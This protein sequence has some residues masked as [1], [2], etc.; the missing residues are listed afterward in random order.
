MGD[1]K[2]NQQRGLQAAACFGSCAVSRREV[3]WIA[4][5][6]AI[7]SDDE[8]CQVACFVEF[9][10]AKFWKINTCIGLFVTN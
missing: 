10:S 8:D 4:S 7:E 5:D 2:M 6:A 3:G 9:S 1:L